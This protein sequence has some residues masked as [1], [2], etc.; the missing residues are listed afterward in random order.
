MV[1]VLMLYPNVSRMAK[2]PRMTTGTASVGISVARRF[3]R[4]RN[5]T[6]NTST[7]A[8]ISVCTTPSMEAE[9]TGVV[10]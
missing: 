2:V 6:R 9:I 1:S 4:N 3:C 10:S 7:K 8:S 5:I